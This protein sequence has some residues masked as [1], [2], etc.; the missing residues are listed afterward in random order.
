MFPSPST[1][2]LWDNHKDSMT[3]DIFHQYRTRC[4]DLTIT[5]S[6]AMYN[7]ALIAIEDLCFVIANLSLS[8]FGMNSPNRTSSD[9]I[10]INTEMNRELQNNTIEMAVIVTCN[11]PLINEEQRTIHL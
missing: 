5:F 9:L 7:E 11:A 10:I 2:I 3:D 6:D 1:P 4:N 8:H